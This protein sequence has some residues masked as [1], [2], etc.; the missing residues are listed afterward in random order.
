M[1]HIAYQKYL[2]LPLATETEH[3]HQSEIYNNKWCILTGLAI[4]HPHPHRYYTLEEFEREYRLDSELRQRFPISIEEYDAWRKTE[5]TRLEA[6]GVITPRVYKKLHEVCP[7][8][9]KAEYTTTLLATAYILGED[10]KDTLNEVRCN[11]GWIGTPH[12]LI[13]KKQ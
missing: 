4:M 2:Q 11:C 5:M 12:D 10:Y 9:F 6:T 13:P 8:C 7:Q 3:R 1:I